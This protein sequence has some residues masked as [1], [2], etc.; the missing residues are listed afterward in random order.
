MVSSARHRV[1]FGRLSRC[2]VAD[3]A[4]NSVP[5]S[6]CPLTERTEIIMLTDQIWWFL[7]R[8]RPFGRSCWLMPSVAGLGIDEE[9]C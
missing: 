1:H 7:A 2:A 6:A 9:E 4:T 3:L 8:G 5:G